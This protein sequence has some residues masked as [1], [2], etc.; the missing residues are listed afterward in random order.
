MNDDAARRLRLLQQEFTTLPAR[1]IQERGPAAVHPPA[2]I[3][4]AVFDHIARSVT[5]VVEHVHAVAPDADPAPAEVARVYDWYRQNTPE[6]DAEEIRV[7]EARIYRQSLEHAIEAGDRSV[8][9]RHPCPACG[10]WGLFWRDGATAGDDDCLPRSARGRAA[11]T[12]RDCVDEDGVGRTWDLA[13]LAHEHT[14]RKN[15]TRRNAT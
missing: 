4:L 1:G 2:P 9:R 8:I 3:N 10:C 12:N 15:E 5:E 7:R 11:C 13:R 6:L 14:A